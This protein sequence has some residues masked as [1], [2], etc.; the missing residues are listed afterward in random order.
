[1]PIPH[2]PG[3][4]KIGLVQNFKQ[5]ANW[6]PMIIYNIGKLGWYKRSQYW[7]ILVHTFPMQ[8]VGTIRIFLLYIF[9]LKI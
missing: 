4:S 3:G 1:M 6:M 8:T 5:Q 7:Q 9:L 2:A